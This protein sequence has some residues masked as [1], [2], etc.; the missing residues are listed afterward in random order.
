MSQ[1][2]LENY[3]V[4]SDDQPTL[5][6]APRGAFGSRVGFILAAAGSAV[7]LGNIWK[8][9]YIT[10]ENGGGMFVLVYLG[11]IAL[12]GLPIMIAEVM[13]GRMTQKSPVG[14]FEAVTGKYSP[15]KAVGGLGVLAGFLMLSFYS[16]VAGWAC[17]YTYLAIRDLISGPS[18]LS[19]VEFASGVAGNAGLNI[20]WHFF[21]MAATML[22]VLGGVKKGIER[23]SKIM[24]PL[25]FLM[26]IYL[27]VMSTSMKGFDEAK[28]F[29]FSFKKDGAWRS[30]SA[31]GILE[32]LGHAFFTLSLGMGA[33]ITYGSYAN[34]QTSTVKSSLS[35]CALDTF[36]ALLACM[37]LFPI[38]F[39]AGLKPA[40]GPGL[41]FVNIPQALEANGSPA[42]L[43]VV[44]FGLLVF[45]ALT[46]AIS[47]LEVV[48]SYFI[49]QWKLKRRTAVL[50][51]GTAIFLVGIPS[52]LSN[53]KGG[54]WNEQF[55][56]GKAEVLGTYWG[57]L[58]KGNWFDMV[59]Y[60]VSNWMLPLGGLLISIFMAWRVRAR[61]REAE[62]GDNIGF[63]YSVWF[64]LL[65]VVI[66]IAVTV[67]MLNKVGLLGG[68]IDSTI[69]WLQWLRP[70]VKNG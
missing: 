64:L 9:P 23:A 47:L 42:I 10:G 28:E 65:A 50:A 18:H 54:L 17:H 62:F 32:A 4:D 69:E 2:D 15:W 67:V 6:E 58:T 35:I 13:L 40:Q 29:V 27:F 12:V 55:A 26:L 25:L 59:D 48:C 56:Q 61:V 3:G 20:G 7:G 41:V 49:D 68:C 19:S 1:N 53:V 33:M 16:I 34:R 21:F 24:M 11:C 30:I 39:S 22:L 60:F 45:A 51:C 52:A 63:F 5:S 43:G 66:P 46:S 8:F 38:S 70:Q 36:V 44:F 14:A 57:E 31:E 37:V